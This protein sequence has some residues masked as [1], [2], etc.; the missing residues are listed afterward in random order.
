MVV[1]PQF[2]VLVGAVLKFNPLRLKL[3]CV[4]EKHA[5]VVLLSSGQ[6]STQFAAPSLSESVSGVPQPQVP[7]LVFAGSLSH[8]SLQSRVPSPSV[9]AS[10]TPQPHAPGAVLPLS[11]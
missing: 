1:V 7:G 6:P 11:F 10:E 5:P 4:N 3:L 8:D 2:N 9:S